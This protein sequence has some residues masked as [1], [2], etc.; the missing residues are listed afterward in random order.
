M[1]HG[2]SHPQSPLESNQSLLNAFLVF[3]KLTVQK[4]RKKTTMRRRRR[5]SEEEDDK[6]RKKM[7][8][9]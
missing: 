5:Q 9:L 3:G 8:S 6:V 4:V 1:R 7:H 2:L